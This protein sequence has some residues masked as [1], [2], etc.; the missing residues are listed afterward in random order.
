MP[1]CTFFGGEGS[2]TKI[3][4]RKKVGGFLLTSLLEGLVNVFADRLQEAKL[5]AARHLGDGRLRQVAGRPNGSDV[6]K[7]G[8]FCK[9]TKANNS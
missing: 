6:A 9:A 7:T 5:Y 1:F 3:E 2:P 8:P 4:Y